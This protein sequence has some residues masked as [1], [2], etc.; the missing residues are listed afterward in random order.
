MIGGAKDQG[1]YK[2]RDDR[3]S[4]PRQQETSHFCEGRW[5][6]NT[7]ISEPPP[8]HFPPEIFFCA[9]KNLRY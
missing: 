4:F 2:A 7:F 9:A 5:L 3:A 8:K 6:K 1:V